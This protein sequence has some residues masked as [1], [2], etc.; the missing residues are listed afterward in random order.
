[1]YHLNQQAGKQKHGRIDSVFSVEEGHEYICVILKATNLSNEDEYI[2]ADDFSLVNS[3]GE[4]L[5]PCYPIVKIWDEYE[6]ITGTTLVSGGSKTGILV[7][8]NPNTDNSNLK[9]KLEEFHWLSDNKVYE[10]NLI[11][12]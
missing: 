5:H 12:N 6:Y 3:N 7:F 1:M 10:I 11:N 8:N 9:L 2:S 4:E